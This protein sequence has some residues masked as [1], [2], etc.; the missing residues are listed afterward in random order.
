MMM[1]NLPKKRKVWQ[2]IRPV[3]QQSRSTTEIKS[4]EKLPRKKF[5]L[6]K[7]SKK[8]FV[9]F[10]IISA[11]IGLAV[12]IFW[13]IKL[14][15]DA[16]NNILNAN[17]SKTTNVDET[18]VLAK[19]TPSFSGV[20][21]KDKTITNYGGW[22]RISPEGTEPVYAYS[23]SIDGV[24]INVSQQ[25]LPENFKDDPDTQLGILAQDFHATQQLHANNFVAYIGTSVDG[26]QSVIF[27][28]KDVLV[29]IKS[30]TII[31]NSSWINYLNSL[32]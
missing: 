23:D 28:K 5:K 16:K 12:T 20:L 8:A 9:I 26:P 30:S 31:I 24:S 2:D 6:P 18:P 14:P 25:S 1:E 13:Y 29:M 19:G 3:K 21:P 11:I 7:I 10:L 22:T 4:I 27:I 15:Q 17:S 32:E